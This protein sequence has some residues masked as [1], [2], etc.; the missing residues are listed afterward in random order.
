MNIDKIKNFL[1]SFDPQQRMKAIQELKNY[2]ANIAVPLLKIN[3][4]DREFLVRSFVAMGLGKKQNAESFATLLEM[5]KLDSDPNVRAE[6]ANSLSLYGTVSASHLVLMFERDEHWLVRR[7]IIAALVE[8]NCSEQLFEVCVLGLTGEDQTVRESCINCL[9]YF[10]RSNWEEAAVEQ[11][12]L[13]TEAQWWG[14]RVQVAKSLGK[15]TNNERAITV[16]QELRQDRDYRV[17]G[18]VLEVSL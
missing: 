10:A 15:F 13:L 4:K 7:S 6:A 3:I 1:V 17:V 14:T 11:L 18:A 5:M 2:E 12:I 8:L 16:L 9:S